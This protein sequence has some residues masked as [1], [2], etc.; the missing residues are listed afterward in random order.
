MEENNINTKSQAIERILIEYKYIKNEVEFLKSIIGGGAIQ[1]NPS[2]RQNK[3]EKN[4]AN[5]V[6]KV[7]DSISDI[8]SNMPD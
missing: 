6:D 1:L 5:E 2:Q 3:I 7:K 4:I 8:F